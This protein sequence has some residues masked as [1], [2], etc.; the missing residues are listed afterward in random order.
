MGLAFWGVLIG[1][2]LIGISIGI[3]FTLKFWDKKKRKKRKKDKF[4]VPL[5]FIELG[6]GF[7][8]SVFGGILASF[9]IVK[10]VQPD[11][12]PNLN[13]STF[14]KVWMFLMGVYL[15]LAMAFFWFS[16]KLKPK[17]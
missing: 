4:T 17:K 8:I 1:G 9:L 12:L 13:T 16:E 7:V 10:I 6:R 11:L 14:Y 15:L 2:V 5:W 3:V